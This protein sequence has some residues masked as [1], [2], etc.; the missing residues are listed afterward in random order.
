MENG[1]LD[2]IEAALL[3]LTQ[4]TE[5]GFSG[6][7]EMLWTL[8]GRMTNF[9]GRMANLWQLPTMQ[10]APREP[11]LFPDD[12]ASLPGSTAALLVEDKSDGRELRHTITHH[13]I[14]AEV[15]RG[16]C[17]SD[18]L[19]EHMRFVDHAELSELALTG[20]AKKALR[21]LAVWDEKGDTAILA[22]RRP[23]VRAA[24]LRMAGADAEPD[25][26]RAAAA[27]ADVDALR[28]SRDG[29]CKSDGGNRAEHVLTEVVRS[30]RPRRHHR[31]LAA[32]RTCGSAR[33]RR[34]EHQQPARFEPPPEFERKRRRHRSAERTSSC[35]IR[36]Y[37]DARSQACPSDVG[38]CPPRT[39]R[40]TSNVVRVP[41][42]SPSG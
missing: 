37:P 19:P 29:H 6:T 41:F 33:Y 4:A 21:V 39:V 7:T 30:G 38:R 14:R 9:E 10:R 13:R 34:I 24:M 5:A 36:A 23:R 1:R 2:R 22:A 15:R 27:V 12:W 11:S 35:G 32:C 20:M 3:Q 26:G 40:P 16:W 42:G 8:H 18:V 28:R 25:V 31:H 17:A